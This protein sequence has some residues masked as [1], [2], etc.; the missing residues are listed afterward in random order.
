MP[1]SVTAVALVGAALLPAV[2]GSAA[3]G[4][5]L[6]VPRDAARTIAA[7]NFASG[8]PRATTVTN[9]G[10]VNG[11]KRADLLVVNTQVHGG[12]D[13]RS[14]L[15]F[16]ANLQKLTRLPVSGRKGFPVRGTV[17]AAGDVNG[18]G[19]ADLVSCIVVA[20]KEVGTILFGRAG[21][22]PATAGGF[23]ITNASR[24]PRRAGDVD[25]DRIDDL[26][27]DGYEGEGVNATVIYGSRRPVSVD[28][29][30][31]GP[32][33]FRI[34][35]KKNPPFWVSPVGDINGDRRADLV[36][37]PAYRATRVRVLLGARRA[38]TVDPGKPGLPTITGLGWFRG[39]ITSAGDINGDGIDDLL[40]GD[41]RYKP[42]AAPVGGRACVIFGKRERWPTSTPGC[43][44]HGGIVVEGA[45]NTAQFADYAGSAGDIDRDGYDDLWVS[46][47]SEQIPGLDFGGGAVYIVYGQKFAGRI[48]IGN[49]ARVVRIIPTAKV[50]EQLGSSVA[51][52][53]D[54]TGDRYSDVVIGG[55]LSG[56]AWVISLGKP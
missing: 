42:N 43:D 54:L 50:G 15:L 9:V 28:A 23:R 19:R 41:T 30:R 33:G 48:N 35:A 29:A 20:G 13:V 11:D 22:R 5:D 12:S 45:S 37:D 16:G 31:P 21:R 34:D 7:S 32:N 46:A 47:Q 14:D 49:D 38:G 39:S 53:G 27:V 52:A 17:A 55:N 2:A 6:V 24:C 44:G 56:N 40:I 51:V 10:D 3:G 25:G 8:M 4:R 18:D 36:I 1:V 26:I